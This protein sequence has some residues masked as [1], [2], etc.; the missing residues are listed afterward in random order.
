MRWDHLAQVALG[1]HEPEDGEGSLDL[2]YSMRA[3]AG[4]LELPELAA[5]RRIEALMD[6]PGGAFARLMAVEDPRLRE[7]EMEAIERSYF[8]SKAH[9]E[10]ER[11]G[12]SDMPRCAVCDK[13]LNPRDIE[14][15][16]DRHYR[17]WKQNAW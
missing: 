8:R 12:P 10:V 16:H 4:L 9:Q 15:G 5:K 1:N 14:K 7:S 3:R 13:P 2:T 6:V 17:C 11:P